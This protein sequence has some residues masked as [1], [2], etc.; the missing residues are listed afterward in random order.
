[1]NADNERNNIVQLPAWRRATIVSA[2]AAVAVLGGVQLADRVW[3]GIGLIVLGLVLVFVG[4]GWPE[5][6]RAGSRLRA[7]IYLVGSVGM[8]L[9]A[10]ALIAL[11]I[12]A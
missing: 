11:R 6:Y 12:L 3:A 1:M 8:I 4:A 9:S 10:A 5:T 2:Y 7:T